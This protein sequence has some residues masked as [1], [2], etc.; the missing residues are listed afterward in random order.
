VPSPPDVIGLAGGNV[1]TNGTSHTINL[2]AS[3][4]S[5]DLLIAIVASDGTPTFTW[6]AGWTSLFAANTAGSESRIEARYRIATGSEGASI[7]VT[8]SASEMTCHMTMRIT[9]HYASTTA[10]EA[11][12][13]NAATSTSPSAAGFT[14]SWGF[15]VALWLHIGVYDVGQTFVNGAHLGSTGIVGVHLTAGSTSGPNQ[16]SDNTAGIGLWLFECATA[17]GSID[18]DGP[19]LNTSRPWRAGVI[20]IR[21]IPDAAGTGPIG[22]AFSG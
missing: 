9:G 7:T 3:I 12:G 11:G 18:F 20:A 1:T 22:S 21:A 5:G 4:A 14:P 2:P 8:T 13:S 19:T 10:P 6:P 15:E 16:R 17:A